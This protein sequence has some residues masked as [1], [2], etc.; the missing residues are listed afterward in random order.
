MVPSCGHRSRNNKGKENINKNGRL[1][2]SL[3]L[4]IIARQIRAVPKGSP[5]VTSK[6]SVAQQL[7]RTAQTLKSEFGK[8]GPGA[9]Q[10]TNIANAH[11]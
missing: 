1:L 8:E 3:Y 6:V 7:G 9:N 10:R 2:R 11:R 5:G 4:D